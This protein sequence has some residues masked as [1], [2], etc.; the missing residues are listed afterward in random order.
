MRLL[1]RREVGEGEAGA[2][3]TRILAHAKESI[4]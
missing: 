4:D 1:G 3:A 2:G